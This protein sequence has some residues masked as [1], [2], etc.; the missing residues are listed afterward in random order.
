[1]GNKVGYRLNLINFN[2]VYRFRFLSIPSFDSN[3]V[4]KNEVKHLDIKR[5]YSV[6]LF[7]KHLMAAEYHAQ[8][9]ALHKN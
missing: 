3:V 6:S 2:S 4:T 9:H 1:M 8:N 5:I 7:T